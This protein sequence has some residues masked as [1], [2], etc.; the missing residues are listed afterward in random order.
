MYPRRMLDTV[1]GY[2]EM[3]LWYPREVSYTQVD[4]RA[5]AASQK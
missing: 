3:V 1:T 4:Q 2:V 5:K